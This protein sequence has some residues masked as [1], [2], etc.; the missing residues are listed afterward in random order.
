MI[1]VFETAIQKQ[2]L[3]LYPVYPVFGNL[4]MEMKLCYQMATL[5]KITLFYFYF[6][7]VLML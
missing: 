3:R 5:T 4:K 7:A 6:M 2:K 1:I